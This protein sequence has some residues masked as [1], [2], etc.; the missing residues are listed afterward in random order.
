MALL[1]ISNKI[2]ESKLKSTARRLFDSS[3]N[4]QEENGNDVIINIEG[5][6]DCVY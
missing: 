5:N 6:G 2:D 4:Y 3:V 1:S